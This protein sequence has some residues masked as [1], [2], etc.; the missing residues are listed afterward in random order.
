M[1]PGR[2][3]TLSETRPPSPAAVAS[4]LLVAI[5]SA[6]SLFAG[7]DHVSLMLPGGLPFGNVLAAGVL[8]GLSGAAVLMAP[9]NGMTRRAAFFALAASVAWLPLSIALAGNASLNF[10]GG[11][12]AVWLW[13]SV[14]LF[15]C[16]LGALVA[17]AGAAFLARRTQG[18]PD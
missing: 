6:G 1:K 2:A 10:S 3:R 14:L 7:A 17:A 4:A 16:V 12:G 9:R 11:L 8:C 15:A 5:F 13:G 18:G